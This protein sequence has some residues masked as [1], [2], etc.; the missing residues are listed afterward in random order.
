MNEVVQSSP[1]R[2]GSSENTLNQSA[3]T[4]VTLLKQ[5]GLT[6]TTAESCT[7]GLVSAAITSVPGASAV[8][9]GAIVTYSPAVK[10][11]F[12]EIDSTILYEV[13]VVS[14]ECAA[15]MAKGAAALFAADAAIAITGNAGPD[16]G[17]PAV[18]VGRVYIAAYL[19]GT[20]SVRA[21]DL[22]GDRQQVRTAA[23]G[24]AIQLLCSRLQETFG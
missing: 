1:D 8:L 20:V 21:L 14:E 12:L 11:R 5:H 17:D 7:G 16:A 9:D 2:L 22:S 3:Q 23:A 6:V 15:A 24:E 10:G 18:P 19:L 4:L 13:G